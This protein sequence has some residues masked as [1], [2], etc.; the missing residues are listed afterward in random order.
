M[1]SG[2]PVTKIQ[3]KYVA[4]DIDRHGNVRRYFRR[5][6]QRKIRLPGPPGSAE[7]MDAYRVALCGESAANKS[8]ATRNEQAAQGSFRWLCEMYFESSEFKQLDDRT[9][10]VRRNIID[11]LCRE[12]GNKPVRLMEVRHVRYIR[13]ARADHFEAANAILKALRQIFAYG[14]AVG[15]VDRNPAKEVPY[16]KSGSP[17]FHSWTSD[18]VRQFEATHPMGSKARLAFALLFYT[19]Q[20]R[21]DIVRFGRQHLRNGKINF[22][23]HKNRNRKPISLS[24]P[25]VRALQEIIE[26]SPCGDLT[27]LVTDF[28]RPFTSSG[29][30]NKF[31]Y[32]CN[33]AGLPQCSAHGLRK[34]RAAELAESG[35]SE[36]EIMAI[37][38]HQT[39]KEV[40]RYT[41]AARQ[42]VLAERAMARITR[43][44]TA[45]KSVP[46]DETVQKSGTNL[47]AK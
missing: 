38:G 33:Q 45:N 27:F 42:E 36:H 43:D 16:L 20:R 46:L 1:G 23:Q 37:T 19:G 13:D 26:K 10:R 21:S 39:S 22:T 2:R 29:F 30:G 6:G 9:K 25:I 12:H 4:E 41:R 17:G 34:A 32:W 15:L 47:R 3:L 5:E 40:S 18:E 11:R 7:F 31:R 8:K 24:I 44:E 35:A 14:V 28:G